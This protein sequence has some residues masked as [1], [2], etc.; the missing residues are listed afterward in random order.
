MCEMPVIGSI[1]LGSGGKTDTQTNLPFC[2][3]LLCITYLGN[4]DSATEQIQYS[5]YSKYNKYKWLERH[6]TAK[7]QIEQ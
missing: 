3:S 6:K 5:M 2:H 7:N 1:H 4:E